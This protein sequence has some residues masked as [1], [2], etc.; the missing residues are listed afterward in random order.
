MFGAFQSEPC[1]AALLKLFTATQLLTSGQPNGN[2]AFVTTS[3]VAQPIS[4]VSAAQQ[5]ALFLMEG[6][7]EFGGAEIGIS[8]DDY[9]AALIVYFTNPGADNP[10]SPQMNAL[11]DAVI[12][13]MR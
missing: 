2:P 4:D 1:F 5:P 3:R 11:R 8:T 12:F 10:A 7:I 13:Q 9:K 6:E